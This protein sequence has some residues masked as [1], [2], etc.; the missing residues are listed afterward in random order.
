MTNNEI[1]AMNPSYP[2]GFDTNELDIEDCERE[3]VEI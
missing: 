3:G 2:P 1:L